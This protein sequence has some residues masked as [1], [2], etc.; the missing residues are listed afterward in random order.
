[1][2]IGIVGTGIAGLVAARRLSERHDVTVYEAND[3]IG[4][5]THT[6][7]VEDEGQRLAVDTGFIV[8]NEHT[9]PLFTKL[10]R[11]LGVSTQPSDMSFSVSSE[12]G[13]LEYA[14]AGLNA[15]FAQ[16]RNLLRPSFHRML[17]DVL[18]FNREARALLGSSEEK[19]SLG[20]YLCGAGYSQEFL[21][22]YILPMGAAIWSASP[23][24]FLTFPAASFARFFHNHGLLD[25]NNPIPWRVVSGGS[26]RYVDALVAPLCN[27][28]ETGRPVLSVLRDRDGVDVITPSGQLDRF[29]RIVLA[30][31]SDQALRLLDEPSHAELRVLSAVR[32]QENDAV[33]HTDRSLMPRRRRAWASWNYRLPESERDRAFVTYHMN[34]LQGLAARNDYLVTLNGTDHI[35]PARIRARFTYHHPVFDA[36]AMAA[37]K[38]HE[39]IDGHRRTHYCGA[40]WGWGF[41]EDGVRSALA[42]CDRIERSA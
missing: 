7:E 16:R 3:Y 10:L 8:Y 26:Q 11:Q 38:L 41:H 9:Y 22:G 29:D 33:L 14:S 40:W 23:A 27:R 31:H 37:Q 39:A 32:F 19:A 34:R 13:F 36:D 5:H 28:I 42:V 2:R 6:V 24:T 35:D 21:D 12:S 1:M 15:I 4:G 30:V 17:R 20:D 25:R 18:R